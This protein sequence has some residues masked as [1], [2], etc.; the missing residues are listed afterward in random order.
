MKFLLFN[1]C[2]HLLYILNHRVGP[3]A[4]ALPTPAIHFLSMLLCVLK[5]MP[6]NNS[7]V[8]GG[9]TV[10]H[11]HKLWITL[12]KLKG[13]C[14]GKWHG[15]RA[16]HPSPLILHSKLTSPFSLFGKCWCFITDICGH[17]CRQGLERHLS[18]T[19]ESHGKLM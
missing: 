7:P 9:P 15:L 11:L 13:S 18:I 12:E 8:T 10:F 5:S 3:L 2:L 16:R 14:S 17:S 19:Q 6:R 4:T 1:P